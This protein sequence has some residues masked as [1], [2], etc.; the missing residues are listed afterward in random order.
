[1]FS[2]EIT[3]LAQKI[4]SGYTARKR[5]LVT[6]E[7]C[8]GGL[9]AAALTEIPG[10]SAVVERGYVAYSNDSKVEVLG[11]L[12]ETLQ[13]SGAVS[14]DIAE[15][16]AQGA[17]EFSLADIAISVTGVAGPDGG[18]VIKP[19]GLVYF[20]LVTRFGARMHSRAEFQGDRGEIRM[21]AVA[22]GLRLL[23]SL[24]EP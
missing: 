5:K 19:V 15:E 20:G 21:Q 7:S 8:T 17:L 14:A 13:L 23:D 10:A 2:P 6:A 9:I 24:I 3:S 22:E 1:M 4:I 11:I 16:M 18:T 12:P